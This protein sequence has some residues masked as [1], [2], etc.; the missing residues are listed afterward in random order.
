[1]FQPACLRKTHVAVPAQ[2]AARPLHNLRTFHPQRQCRAG[3]SL[4]G[5]CCGGAA[6]A[7]R[8]ALRSQK[9]SAEASST[10]GL[11][12]KK[13][14]VSVTRTHHI[15]VDEAGNLQPLY[16]KSFDEVLPFHEPGL[17]PVRRGGL[18]WHIYPDGSNAY[19]RT[20]ARTFGFY[21]G[22]A[23]VK[24]EDGTYHHIVSSGE[25]LYPERFDVWL[26]W[27]A[28][29]FFWQFLFEGVFLMNITDVGCLE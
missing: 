2:P 11:S 19:S 20:F 13:S 5:A 25:D 7:A 12:W 15:I 28:L 23:S 17:A 1:M 10:Q 24:T 8:M 26:H 9:H 18:A 27:V 22:R 6:R 4:V 29:F 14:R 16:N 21:E 3:E